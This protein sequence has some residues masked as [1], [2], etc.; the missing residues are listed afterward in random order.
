MFINKFLIF[1]KNIKSGA[2]LLFIQLRTQ[3]RKPTMSVVSSSPI[4]SP[5]SGR[6]S[7]NS[8][9]NLPLFSTSFTKPISQKRYPLI[10]FSYSKLKAWLSNSFLYF[11]FILTYKNF[12]F[13]LITIACQNQELGWRVRTR[14]SCLNDTAL[15]QMSSYLNRLLRFVFQGNLKLETLCFVLF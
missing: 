4:L 7:S 13:M 6:L 10:V 15:I 11:L 14:K 8:S 9:T 5:S 12:N 2:K 1:L 3:K